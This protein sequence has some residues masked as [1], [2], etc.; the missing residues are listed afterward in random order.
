MSEQ[1]WNSLRRLVK[2]GIIGVISVV[3]ISV[4]VSL[5]LTVSRPQ[6]AFYPFFPFHFAW[7]G[8]IFLI[9]AFF[10]IARWFIF[11]RRWQCYNM[12]GKSNDPSHILKERYAKGEITKEQFEQ[13]MQDLK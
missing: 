11:P 10:W 3:G 9:F 8:G 4:I 13:M 1:E 6:G 7:I 5:A 12:V 2:W